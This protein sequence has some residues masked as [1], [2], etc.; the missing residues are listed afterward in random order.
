MKSNNRAVGHLGSTF[1]AHQYICSCLKPMISVCCGQTGWFI[2]L[3]LGF[4]GF[5]SYH[6]TEGRS[7][8]ENERKG[9]SIIFFPHS[10]TF[11]VTFTLFVVRT[12][13]GT[14]WSDLPYLPQRPSVYNTPGS[15]MWACAFARQP[16][17]DA[18]GCGKQ[19]CSLSVISLCS[20]LEGRRRY[21]IALM[22]SIRKMKPI[23]IV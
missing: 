12:W 20:F 19:H 13:I 9:N 16:V 22:L 11:C 5:L 8:P 3:C 17:W 10:L 2:C 15:G 7:Q 4:G 6:S 23:I 21:C 18:K 1:A 14:S